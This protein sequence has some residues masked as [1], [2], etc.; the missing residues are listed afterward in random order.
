MYIVIIFYVYKAR[1]I[2]N[3]NQNLLYLRF[4]LMFFFPNNEIMFI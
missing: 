1:K 4:V 2:E 3:K